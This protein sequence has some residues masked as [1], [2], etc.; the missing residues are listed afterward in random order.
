MQRWQRH[1]PWLG[2]GLQ[3]GYA[4]QPDLQFVTLSTLATDGCK[5]SARNSR[6]G[7]P[8]AMS[9]DMLHMCML[10]SEVQLCARQCTLQL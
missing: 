2:K 10:D 6:S 7:I 8:G 4:M 9:G 1:G 5:L 3:V